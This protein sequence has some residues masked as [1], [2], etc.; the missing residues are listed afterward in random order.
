M[1][2]NGL[3]LNEFALAHFFIRSRFDSELSNLGGY[4]LLKF[5]L[6]L[7]WVGSGFGGA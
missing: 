1:D 4:G 6:S 2:D 7:V 5:H 3:G